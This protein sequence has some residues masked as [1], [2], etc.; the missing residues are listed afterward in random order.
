MCYDKEILLKI[1][2]IEGTVESINNQM[3]TTQ[4]EIKELR[5]DLTGVRLKTV[6]LLSI[7]SAFCGGISGDLSKLLY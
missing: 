3:G 4:A 6:G 2:K 7:L 1:G 5:K